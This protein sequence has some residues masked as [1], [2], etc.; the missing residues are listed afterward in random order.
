M[1]IS[2]GNRVNTVRNKGGI[3][4]LLALMSLSLL[5]LAFIAPIAKADTSDDVARNLVSQK[6]YVTQ[7]VKANTTF[8]A[9][10]SN[11]EQQVKD[12][13][14]KVKGKADTRIAVISNQIIPT[15]FNTNTESYTD[16]LYGL[17]NKPSVLIVV[18]AQ[19]SQVTLFSDE[20]SASE[21]D[22]LIADTK[23]TFVGNVTNGTVQLA[24][25]TADKIAGKNT[26]SLLTTIAVVVIVILL[27]VGTA[28]FVL[29][30]TKKSWKQRL[31]GLEQLAN[32]VSDQ[33]VKVSD[34]VNFLPDAARSQTTA[35]FGA[36]TRNF[37]E[38]NT[39]LSEL[40]KV[41]S[42]TLL[43]KG[44][45]Y[46]RKLDMTGAQFDEARRSLARIEQQMQRSLPN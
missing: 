43:L 12:T 5:L 31:S 45:D 15:K 37:S 39:R 23:P 8:M 9:K 32:Q 26:A 36:A 20:L 21:R 42:V 4:L 2:N 46:S 28:V 22:S 16:S 30:N 11:I 17:L 19:T 1:V 33:V 3:G 35:E 38:A 29:V 13:V 24:E 7:D 41:S 18:N 40:Q 44:A 25:K 10:N 14:N 27:I 34:D 6:Y